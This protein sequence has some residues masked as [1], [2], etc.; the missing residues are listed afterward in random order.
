[1]NWE[2]SISLFLDE[3]K[4]LIQSSHAAMDGGYNL[5]GVRTRPLWRLPTGRPKRTEPKQSRLC[6]AQIHIP[7]PTRESMDVPHGHRGK[8]RNGDPLLFTLYHVRT[9][10]RA[11]RN[12]RSQP[13]E[14]RGRKETQFL[15]KFPFS[16]WLPFVCFKLMF[17]CRI[18]THAT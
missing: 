7:Q 10:L 11:S 13:G 9:C 12:C 8:E 5:Q 16:N 15:T 14:L 2:N 6:G 4:A 18:Q 1:M 3:K 17:S